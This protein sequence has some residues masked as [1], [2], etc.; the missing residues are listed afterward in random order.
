MAIRSRLT[1]T[2]IA[3]LTAQNVAGN[4]SNNLTAAGTT[5]GTALA[6]YDEMNV[7]TTVA[8]SSGAILRADLGP[9]DEQEAANYG[10]NALT[11]YPPV[12]GKIQNGS[13]NAGFSVGTNKTARF[14]SIDGLAFTAVLS[15]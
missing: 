9:G 7:F 10:A 2:G 4:V 1:G 11:V 14:R 6:I 12:G 5:Q 3:P 13:V 15:S 8:A